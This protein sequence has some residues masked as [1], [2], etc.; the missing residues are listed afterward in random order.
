MIKAEYI[1]HMGSDLT[2]VNSAKVSFNKASGWV[3]GFTDTATDVVSKSLSDRDVNLIQGLA[4]GF[5]AAD[6]E[7]LKVQCQDFIDGKRDTLP[8]AYQHFTPFTHEIIT[9]RETVP[10]FVARQRFKHMIGFS[11]SEVSRRYVDDEPEF[12]VPETWRK[13]AENKKQGSSDETLST[14]PEKRHDLFTSPADFCS[15]EYRFFLNDALNMYRLLL[16]EGV[17]PEQARMVLPQSMMTS[18]YVTGSLAAFARMYKQRTDS[19]AQY[20]IRLLA[21][22][23]GSIIEPLYPQAW[24]ALTS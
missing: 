20:E 2:V 10:I 13:R 15:K 19:H 22:A 12:Y 4:R 5:W 7:D 17:C 21:D 16:R 14:D 24:K 18:Y 23:V 1:Q 8:E 6:R 9:L 3:Y 11:Y